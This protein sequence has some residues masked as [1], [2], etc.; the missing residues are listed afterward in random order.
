MERE[1]RCGLGVRERM[2]RLWNRRG[3]M[4][5]ISLKSESKDNKP[6]VIIKVYDSVAFVDNSKAESVQYSKLK[7]I[8]TDI[9]AVFTKL[10]K[11]L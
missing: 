9:T 2:L 7:E 1:L 11:P 5:K 8:I 10:K 4:N 6:T 3:I